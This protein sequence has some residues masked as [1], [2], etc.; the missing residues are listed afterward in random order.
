MNVSILEDL[1]NSG[2]QH[3]TNDQLTP[4]M[5]K[6]FFQIQHRPIDF[7]IRKHE[8]FIDMASNSTLQRKYHL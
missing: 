6:I 1:Y 7:N 5:G 3:L 2:N 8:K 4:H